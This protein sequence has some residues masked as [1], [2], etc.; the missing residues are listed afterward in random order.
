M[1]DVVESGVPDP[2]TWIA[3]VAFVSPERP[4][5]ESGVPDPMTWIAC[6]AP[7]DRLR[8]L[9]IVCVAFVSPG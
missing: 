4:V 5:V 3:C 6:V 9:W 1:L 8:G 2:M 7:V